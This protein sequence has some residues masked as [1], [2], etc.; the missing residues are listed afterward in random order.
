MDSEF[1]QKL[2]NI[3]LTEEEGEVIRVG[4]VHRDRILEE[5]SLSLFERFLTNKSFNQRAAKALLRSVWKMGSDVRIVDVGDRI[6]GLPFD[7][8]S[9]EVGRDIGNGLGTVVEVDLKAFSSDQARFLRQGFPYGE[10]LK[11]GFRKNYAT[12]NSGGSFE[13]REIGQNRCLVEGG[14]SVVPLKGGAEFGVPSKGGAVIGEPLKG[15]SEIGLGAKVGTVALT[16][17]KHTPD[18]EE[19][20]SELD[21]AIQSEPVILNSKSIQVEQLKDKKDIY[22]GLVDIEVMDEDVT[23]CKRALK[24]K[25]AEPCSTSCLQDDGVSFKIDK[26]NGQVCSNPVKGMPKRSGINNKSGLLSLQ[27]PL[28]SESD[29]VMFKKPNSKDNNKAIIGVAGLKKG[30]WKRLQDKARTSS[31]LALTKVLGPKRNG[32]EIFREA[33]KAE[34]ANKKNKDP[35][36]ETTVEEAWDKGLYGGSGDVLN[37]CLESCRARLEVWNGSEF[38]NVGKTVVNLQR[39]LE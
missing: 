11:A 39:K 25:Q 35:R 3:T 21:Q 38:G 29:D 16:A 8:L 33:E 20:I 5:C 30:T 26:G 2:K 24:G 34:L 22:S 14:C 1:V 32:K 13:S 6:W 28:S 10:W 36:C 23:S 4:T 12:A 17:G 7:L 19:L 37:R 15:G 9:E 31:D 18:F 27:G